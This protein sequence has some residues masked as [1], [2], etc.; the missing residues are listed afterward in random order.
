MI[1]Q[2]PIWI[3]IFNGTHDFRSNSVTVRTTG[4][5]NNQVSGGKT[6]VFPAGI[7]GQVVGAGNA[8]SQ[9]V[10]VSF[11]LTSVGASPSEAPVNFVVTYYSSAL[12]VLGTQ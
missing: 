5:S 3:D 10:D 7:V 4:S 12:E 11:W 1:N 6:Y 2:V 8:G 9:D